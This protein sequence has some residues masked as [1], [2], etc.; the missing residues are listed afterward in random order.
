MLIMEKLK[1]KIEF[2]PVYSEFTENNEKI[3]SD[4]TATLRE[5][6][7]ALSSNNSITDEIFNKLS[8]SIE[9]SNAVFRSFS[10]HDGLELV[11]RLKSVLD[12]YRKNINENSNLIKIA[13]HII[14][15][16]N[17]FNSTF[18]HEATSDEI[19]YPELIEENQYTESR[20]I[21]DL[22]YKWTTF[23]RN[24]SLFIVQYSGLDIIDYKSPESG[25]DFEYNG[26]STPFIELMKT[27]DD[28]YSP[29]KKILIIDGGRACFPADR[30][31]RQI[32]GSYD[33]ISPIIEPMEITGN[34]I[35]GRVRIFGRK[36]LV[37]RYD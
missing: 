16:L 30:T 7:T 20:Q 19:V 14:K 23:E 10:S 18:F 32:H 36:H 24:G 4:L 33:L 6:I 35:S 11:L 13:E 26:K 17:R 15:K 31:G 8:D 27:P 25:R 28:E 22:K 2:D 9:V 29:P 3:L 34:F 21:K 1:N 12:I 5:V 37:I